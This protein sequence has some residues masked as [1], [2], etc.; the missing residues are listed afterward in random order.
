[1]TLIFEAGTDATE[2]VR[3][4]ARASGRDIKTKW[5]GGH[6]IYMTCAS[7]REAPAEDGSDGWACPCVYTLKR[8]QEN[9]KFKWKFDRERTKPRHSDMCSGGVSFHIEDYLS[10]HDLMR[11]LESNSK[12]SSK[13]AVNATFSVNLKDD[14]VSVFLRRGWGCKV[15][16]E[17]Y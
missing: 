13:R 15:N 7:E 4:Q 2:Y 3:K 12:G 17:G 11:F 10:R 1:M 5:K 8:F 14:Q 6:T 9:K 16:R